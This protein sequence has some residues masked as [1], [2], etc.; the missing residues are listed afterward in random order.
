MDPRDEAKRA[1][2]LA[3]AGLAGDGMAIGLGTG[4][5]VGF[6]LSALASRGLRGY[7]CVSTSPH[8]ERLARRLGLPVQEFDQLDRLDLA[9][10]G[11]D[12][13]GPDG[14]VVKGGGGAHTREKVVAAAASRFVVIVSEDK[15]VGSIGPP[16][17]VDVLSFGLRATLRRL[18]QLGPVEVR[19][20]PPTPDAN[21]IVDYRGEVADPGALAVALDSVPGV[22][23]HG[24]FGPDLVTDVLVGRADGSAD[25]L[26]T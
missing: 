3:A 22:V 18:S 19:P 5:T 25:S 26:R 6:F 20:A 9:V 10:D 8:T 17:P 15:L 21:V 23:A 11:A 24:L 16:I 14:W 13:V 7:R 4:T 12:Q 2:A 1:A